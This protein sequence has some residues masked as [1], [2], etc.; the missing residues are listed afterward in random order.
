MNG[1]LLIVIL[2]VALAGGSTAAYVATERKAHNDEVVFLSDHVKTYA[3][4]VST[5]ARNDP[6]LTGTLTR[7]Q[8]NVPAFLQLEPTV[9]NYVTGGVAYVYFTPKSL[10]DGNEIARK[11]GDSIVCGVKNASNRIVQPGTGDDALPAPAA[12]PVGSFV[13]RLDAGDPNCVVPDRESTIETSPET[14]TGNCPAGQAGSQTLT[15]TRE[16]TAVA[17]CPT[18]NG[19]LQWSYSGWS[20]PAWTVAS[21]TCVN[22]PAGSTETGTQW[23]GASATCAAG[24]YGGLSWE[25]QQSRT[26]SVSYNCPA[27]TATVPPPTYGAWS[28]WTDN[29]STRNNTGSCTSCP[30]PTNEAQTQ[31]VGASGAG[32]PAGTYGTTSWEKQQTRNRTVSYSCPAG[33]AT[34]PAPTYGAFSG[35]ADTGATRNLSTAACTTCPAPT[36]QYEYQWVGTQQS[37]SAGQYG[38]RTWERQ[39]VRSRSVSYSCPAGGTSPPAPIYGAWTGWSDTGTTRN[40]AGSCTACQATSTQQNYQWVGA[41]QSCPS[42][43]TGSWTWQKQQ[44]QSRTT[45]QNCPAGTQ[46]APAISDTGWSGWSDTGAKQG[47]SNTCQAVVQH[48]SAGNT[49]RGVA[50]RTMWTNNGFSSSSDTTPWSGGMSASQISAF[51]YALDHQVYTS[52]SNYD[53]QYGGQ[54]NQNQSYGYTT[55]Y[56]DPNSCQTA[57]DIG[58]VMI[59]SSFNM[60]C[61]MGQGSH[62]C[63]YYFENAYEAFASCEAIC[64]PTGQPYYDPNAIRTNYDATCANAN[65]KGNVARDAAI[66]SF[67]SGNPARYGDVNWCQANNYRSYVHVTCS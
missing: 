36:T 28:G 1:N 11:C 57:S 17:S 10:A 8:A 26:R 48:C 63:D 21:S 5:A 22:C 62:A 9:T 66:G 46:T 60:D 12:A 32:C 39:Q 55:G 51:Q 15:R 18:P 50:W 44:V 40:Q 56:G 2:M 42:G 34:L 58:R 23:V 65:P 35:W 19:A 52:Y 31:W 29:G 54:V 6:S 3:N 53:P 30:S 64:S 59:N 4:Y 41:S 20:A 25:K 49:M 61:V 37:C 45:S 24:Q 27:G 13:M 16:R 43:Q 67:C 14:T 7:A 47:E 33:T 38:L